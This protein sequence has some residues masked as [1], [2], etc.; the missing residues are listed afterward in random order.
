MNDDTHLFDIQVP[1][2]EED[3]FYA[4]LENVPNLRT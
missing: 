2:A 4:Y 3:V 1:H